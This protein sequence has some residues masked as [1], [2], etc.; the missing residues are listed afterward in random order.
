MLCEMSTITT[1]IS[2]CYLKPC[3]SGYFLKP[4]LQA[5]SEITSL[6]E[7]LLKY[8]YENFETL[9]RSH[10]M[11]ST[12]FILSYFQYYFRIWLLFLQFW[13]YISPNKV[14]FPILLPELNILNIRNGNFWSFSA[15]GA[16]SDFH[17]F[18]VQSKFYQFTLWTLILI[19]QLLVALAIF[20]SYY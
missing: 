12:C 20:W 1:P 17:F 3:V 4:C 13:C 11:F 6:I 19:S 7:T 9:E 16:M 8:L 10:H 15:W 2:K 5:Q 18:Q 14:H